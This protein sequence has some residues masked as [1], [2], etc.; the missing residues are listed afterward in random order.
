[1]SKKK[2]AFQGEQGAFSEQAVF[3]HYGRDVDAVPCHDL[4][5]V[6]QAVVHEEVFEGLVPVE[7]AQAGTINKTYDLLL[8]YNLNIT[9]ETYLEINHCFLA[10]EGVCVEDVERV[11]S[12]PQALMQCEEFLQELGVQQHPTQDTAGGARRV[13]DSGR[14]DE[15]AI[16]SSIAAEEHGL[17]ILAEHIETRQKNT[18]RFLSIGLQP[19]GI[20]ENCKTSILFETRDIPAALYKCLGGFATNGVNL[21]KLESRPEREANWKYMFYLDFEG[22][23]NDSPV[24]RALEELEY[25]TVSCEVISSYPKGESV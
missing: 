11:Y 17:V 8:D 25:F 23:R 24:Q 14:T 2:V 20:T 19:R 22:H 16:A 10:N 15:A 21:T 6:F 9:G 4:S 18:T 7:N 1:M 13:R 3:K 5:D 12:H